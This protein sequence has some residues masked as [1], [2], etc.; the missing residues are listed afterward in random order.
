VGIHLIEIAKEEK[1]EK[2]IEIEMTTIVSLLRQKRR[3]RGGLEDI[4]SFLAKKRK[5]GG[6]KEKKR[7]SVCRAEPDSEK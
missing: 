7:T 3:V 1:R 4:K 5:K 2:E 6:G